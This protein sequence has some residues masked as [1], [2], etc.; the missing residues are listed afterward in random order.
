[1]CPLVAEDAHQIIV[2]EIKKEAKKYLEETKEIESL[3]KKFDEE[4]DKK[5]MKII[6]RAEKGLS[7]KEKIADIEFIK[8]RIYSNPKIKRYIK[9]RDIVELP[10]EFEIYQ[11]YIE[12]I[13][14][15]KKDKEK[16]LQT[17]FPEFEDFLSTKIVNYIEKLEA[18]DKARIDDLTD[19]KKKL[20]EIINAKELC[21][22]EEEDSLKAKETSLPIKIKEKWKARSTEL[23]PSS[24]EDKKDREL[25]NYIKNTTSHLEKVL[26]EEDIEYWGKRLQSVKEGVSLYQ[27]AKEKKVDFRKLKYTLKLINFPIDE[28]DRPL[29]TKPFLIF[30]EEIIYPF[31]KII[32]KLEAN[33]NGW[34]ELLKKKGYTKSNASHF[35][36]R[37][38]NSGIVPSY[39]FEILTPTPERLSYLINRK[40]D[41][42][43]Q[44]K[45]IWKEGDD[46]S[47]TRK[48]II[49]LLRKFWKDLLNTYP[50]KKEQK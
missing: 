50:D 15:W 36:R 14:Q 22:D 34:L 31:I 45:W 8:N 5:T 25:F 26:F 46:K 4:V 17:Q 35:I 32:W 9:Y 23:P 43:D 30:F 39:Y 18:E 21:W 47:T 11:N 1:M 44:P 3:M 38:I 48:E 42:I 20:I 29:I 27:L 10:N 28:I 19:E 13:I 6:E 2:E 12:K 16:G 24:K 7:D 37:K 40:K 33:Y 41:P 49:E